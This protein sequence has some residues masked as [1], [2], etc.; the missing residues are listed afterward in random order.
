MSRSVSASNALGSLP[1]R[2][3]RV[4]RPTRAAAPMRKAFGPTGATSDRARAG[5]RGQAG[6]WFGWALE[7][8]DRLG[9]DRRRPSEP[10]GYRPRGP[11]CAV[12]A[13]QKIVLLACGAILLLIAPLWL[14][15][16]IEF[17]RTIARGLE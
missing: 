7:L 4:N 2:T 6:P 3:P 1:R 12:S 13:D 8:A 16:D 15:I 9:R 5:A 11:V 14:Q 10:R 17:A